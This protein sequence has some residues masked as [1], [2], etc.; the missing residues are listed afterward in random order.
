MKKLFIILLSGI[1]IT[2]CQKKLLDTAPYDAASSATMWTTD[3]LTDQGVTGV[4]QAMRLS[5]ATGGATGNELY[6]FD[7]YAVTGQG[8]DLDPLLGGTITSSNGLFSVN[9]Q[10]LYEGVKRANDAIKN[11]PLKSPSADTKKARYIA[12]CKFL[13]GYFYFRLNQ[14]FKGVPLYLEN[15]D[16]SGATKPRET[17]N[18]IWDAVIK[19]LTDA[20][21]EVNLPLK[22][23]SGDAG[24]GHVT[25]GAAYALRGKV[26]MYKK[27][28]VNAIAD[29]Q[30]VKDAGYGLFAGSYKDVLHWP[31]RSLMK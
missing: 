29:F 26:Y 18:A 6:Q 15:V 24:N 11:I 25:K 23:A 12:E 13:R 10:Q 9:W 27:D 3:A 22:Y 5:I 21:N 4:Y 20:I 14:L 8:R 19:D 30:Q 2:G 31:T 16:V 17:E 7:R 28:W 1:A